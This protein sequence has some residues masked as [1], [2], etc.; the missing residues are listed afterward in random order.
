MKRA[1]KTTRRGKRKSKVIKRLTASSINKALTGVRSFRGSDLLAL[2][3]TSANSDFPVMFSSLTNTTYTTGYTIFSAAQLAGVAAETMNPQSIPATFVADPTYA[4]ETNSSANPIKYYGN[5]VKGQVRNCSLNP[6]VIDIY[7]I[8]ASQ[9]FKLS[10]ASYNSSIFN[11]LFNDTYQ[12][13]SDRINAADLAASIRDLAEAAYLQGS[14]SGHGFLMTTDYYSVIGAPQLKEYFKVSKHHSVVLAPGQS[15]IW[16]VKGFRPY[17]YFKRHDG[18][19]TTVANQTYLPIIR[20][21]GELGLS[22]AGVP[23]YSTVNIAAKFDWGCKAY[24]TN[25]LQH[26]GRGNY[27]PTMPATGTAIYGPSDD[28]QVA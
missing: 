3:N 4:T 17:T 24:K 10:L 8:I 2:F 25:A 28:V 27:L 21:R 15:Y 1:T 18:S 5:W 22:T 26:Q 16:K 19:N 20:A 12:N 14:A 23:G 7:D 11:Y 13:Y 6:V 9:D